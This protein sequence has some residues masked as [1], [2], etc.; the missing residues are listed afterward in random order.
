MT[1][2]QRPKEEKCPLHLPQSAFPTVPPGS[3]THSHLMIASC[4]GVVQWQSRFFSLSGPC[5]EKKCRLLRLC[6]NVAVL[7]AG[8]QLADAL[9]RQKQR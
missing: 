8:S 3:G 4:S 5:R 1:H 6:F 7:G 9:G 2:V